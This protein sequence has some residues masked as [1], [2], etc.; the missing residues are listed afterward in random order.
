MPDMI[1]TRAQGQIAHVSIKETARCSRLVLVSRV[2][3]MTLSL[4]VLPIP[5]VL[6]MNPRKSLAFF[7]PSLTWAISSRKGQSYARCTVC[8]RDASVAYGGTKDLRKH[9]QTRVHQASQKGQIGATSLT[10]YF[11][12]GMRGPI[13]EQSVIEAEV[14]FG[15]FLGE[16]H[17]PLHVADHC[18]KLFASMFPDST[19]AKSFRCRRK[20]A[21]ATVEVVAQEVKQGVLS[22][23]KESKFFSIQIDETTDVAVKQ[24]CGIM[25]RFFDHIEG[26]VR[27]PFYKLEPVESATA[28]GI[29]QY[30]DKL[31]CDDGPLTYANLVGLGSDGASVKLG[32]RNSVL[33]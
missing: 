25:L 14:K 30:L 20:K 23:L 1:A 17:I 11:A 27:C 21:T 8:N 6:A 5:L 29:F 16:H 2:N 3:Q 28:D 15:Y 12:P 31:F 32:S 19:I 10:S 22:H 18:S 33:T 9:E 4:I 24:Q 26:K 7:T 13:R